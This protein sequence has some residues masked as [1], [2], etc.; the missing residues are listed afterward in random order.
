MTKPVANIK[1]VAEAAGVSKTTVSHVLSGRRPVAEGTRSVVLKVM[2]DLGFQPNYF[3]RALTSKR[4]LTI[5]LIVQDMTNPFYP[6]LGR[7]LQLAVSPA[8]Y[9]VMYFDAGASETL[10]QAFVA[11]ALE[12][13]V[14]GVVAAVSGI[15]TEILTLQKAGIPVVAV[16]AGRSD[17]PV[18][19]VSADDE[20]IARDAVVYLRGQGH[21]R[22]ATICG[23][24]TRDPGERRLKG[25]VDEQRRAGVTD[26]L[27][28]EGDW[29]RESGAKGMATLLDSPTPPTAVFCANDL[30]AIGAMDLA[31]SR[32]VRVPQ[33]IAMVGVDNIDA[34]NLVRPALTTMHIP[35]VEIGRTAGDLL[36]SRIAG[37]A[38]AMRH[39]MVQHDFIGRQSA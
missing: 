32:G 8:N 19:W 4:S 38:G 14:D 15:D 23:P 10:A 5:A 25:F 34:S 12:R 22:I 35:A 13:R 37:T 3:A 11:A 29:T 26:I 7:G 27:S 2:A 30:M 17:L 9:V 28:A 21:N 31:L 39:V 18:D 24:S 20:R 6:A 1:A 33:D 36:M 16:G